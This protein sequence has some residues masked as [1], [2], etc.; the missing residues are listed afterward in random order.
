MF[1]R[2][3]DGLSIPLFRMFCVFLN[4]YLCFLVSHWEKYNTGV[5]Y[6]PWGYDFSMVCS[7]VMYFATAAR[8]MGLWKVTLPGGFTSAQILEPA[9]YLGNVGLTLPIAI[10]NIRKAYKEVSPAVKV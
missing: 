10:Y 8:G 2:N 9:C 3:D 4:I 5:L 6:L 1:G 7:F